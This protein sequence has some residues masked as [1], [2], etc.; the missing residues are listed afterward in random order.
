MGSQTFARQRYDDLYTTHYQGRGPVT[1]A[2][3]AQAQAS[4]KLDPLVDPAGYDVIRQSLPRF[5]ARP[6]GLWTLTIGMPMAVETRLDTTASMGNNVDIALRVLPDTFEL[7]QGLLPG[8]DLQM[9]IGIFGDVIDRFVLCRPQFEMETD[10]LI[11]ALTL[12]VPCRGGGGNGGEDP[13]YGL[14]GAAYLTDAR[15]NAYGLK[16]YDF[17]ISDEPMHDHMGKDQLIRIFGDQ[18]FER[19][20]ENGFEIDSSSLPSVRDIVS[21]L[22][23]TCH[24]FAL[25]VD[26]R[27]DA[28]YPNWV[29]FYGEDR[30]VRLPKSELLPQVQAAI[31]GLTEGTLALDTVSDFLQANGVGARDAQAVT[32]SVANIPIGAQVP[33]REGVELPVAGDVFAEKTDLQPIDPSQVPELDVVAT[34]DDDNAPAWL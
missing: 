21:Q 32:R 2:A 18:V 13:Q 25:V 3:E 8:M 9:A 23:E 12:Q 16:R 27:Y 19:A 31:V 26:S 22:M 30:V 33:L 15:I 17:T 6:D 10:K 7:I 11:K 5:D 29:S 34:S 14:F 24:A 1:R 4:G 28:P 20:A